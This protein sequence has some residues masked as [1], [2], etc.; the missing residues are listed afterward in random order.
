VQRLNCDDLFLIHQ[1]RPF[2]ILPGVGCQ[3][4]ENIKQQ[5]SNKSF[6]GG[7]DNLNTELVL[8]NG[9]GKI[10]GFTRGQRPIFFP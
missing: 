8:V 3:P 10:D 4:L 2:F 1:G 9:S 5:I 7:T 6:E